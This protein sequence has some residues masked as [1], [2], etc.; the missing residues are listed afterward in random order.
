MSEVA[1]PQ[2]GTPAAP[3]PGAAAQGAA[4][5]FETPWSKAEGVYSIG[6]GENAK[7]WWSGIQ[8]EPIR[9]YA[10]EKKYANPEEALRAAWN[11]NKLNKLTPDIE[12]FVAGKA[13]PEQEATIHKLM[14]RPENADAY[15]LKPAEGVQT[16][17]ELDA[18]AKKVFFE[19]GVPPARAQKAYDMYNEGV[20]AFNAAQQA[21]QQAANDQAMADLTKRWGSD[22]EANRV[23]GNKAVHAL[24]I[25]NDL[26]EKIEA[27]IGSAAIVEL[28]AVI[29]KKMGE[30]SFQGASQSTDPNDPNTMTPQ[31]AQSRINTLQADAEFQKKYTDANHPEHKSAVETMQKLFARAG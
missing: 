16:E 2:T 31:A 7:P 10:E 29:G 19:L 27:N 9:A 20:T 14:G 13:T 24:G 8:E 17:A 1:A 28:L 12:A 5:G 21:A 3:E 30:G 15:E 18:L 22:L 6:E 23:A 11:A 25:A 26:V 4:Q